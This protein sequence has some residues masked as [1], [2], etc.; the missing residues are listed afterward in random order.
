VPRRVLLVLAALAG[1]LGVLAPAASAAPNAAVPRGAGAPAVGGTG[2]P[3]GSGSLAPGPSTPV[4][5]LSARGDVRHGVSRRSRQPGGWVAGVA[6]VA[7]PSATASATAVAT[8]VADVLAV[9]ARAVLPVPPLL[10]AGR[11]PRAPDAALRARTD[12]QPPGRAPP[13]PAGT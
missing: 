5:G 10:P 6:T 7:A 2:A 9:L 13:A 4:P 3:V 11:L 1:L 8:G 12:V